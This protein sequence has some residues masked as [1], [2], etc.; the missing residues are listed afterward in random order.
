MWKDVKKGLF[1]TDA[2]TA[3]PG[4]GASVEVTNVGFADGSVKAIAKTI[5]AE[6]LKALLTQG[7]GE[8][9]GEY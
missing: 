9:V 8:V 1:T 2:Q 3:A 4:A 7:G 6:T 5:D